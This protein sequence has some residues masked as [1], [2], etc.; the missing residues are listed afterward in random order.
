VA[1]DLRNGVLHPDQFPVDVFVFR[2]QLVAANTRT[3][4]ALSEAGLIPTKINIVEPSRNILRRLRELPILA[5][6]T[7][8]GR[9]VPVTPTQNDLTIL[10]VINIPEAR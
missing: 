2:N 4:S 9:S 3:L 8:P 7:L 5:D 6:S 10:R 1:N